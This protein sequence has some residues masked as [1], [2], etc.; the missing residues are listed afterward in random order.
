[1][2]K[3]KLSGLALL[4]AFSI[5]IGNAMALTTPGSGYFN[6]AP[7]TPTHPHKPLIRPGK[8]YNLFSGNF[9]GWFLAK[10]TTQMKMP[11]I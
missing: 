11:T 10:F 4:L 2:S 1:M 7:S 9:A 8:E 6:D 5:A 3:F